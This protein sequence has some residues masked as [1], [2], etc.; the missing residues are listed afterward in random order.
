MHYRLALQF[1]R[2]FKLIIKFRFF[3]FVLIILY[4]ITVMIIFRRYTLC[5]CC[6]FSSL[7]YS[8]RI[9]LPQFCIVH[10]I[11]S[12]DGIWRLLQWWVLRF[13]FF[14]F[15]FAVHFS[16]LKNFFNEA[17][18][19]FLKWRSFPIFK[20]IAN[21]KWVS[22]IRL[23]KLEIAAHSWSAQFVHFIGNINSLNKIYSRLP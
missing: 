7:V 1:F 17:F 14:F 2:K 21:L 12:L 18:Y 10:L 4:T 16:K 22:K 9:C 11:N 19:C 15:C 20:Y 8:I 6:C 13:F 5:C 23:Q 3:C